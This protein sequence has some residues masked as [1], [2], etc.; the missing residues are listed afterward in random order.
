V[1]VPAGA[2]GIAATAGASSGF[3]RRQ[4]RHVLTALT[5]LSRAVDRLQKLLVLLLQAAHCHQDT[6]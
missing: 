1:A 4:Q 5:V 2:H 6:Y 3:G